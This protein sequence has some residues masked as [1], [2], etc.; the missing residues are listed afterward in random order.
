MH[1]AAGATAALVASGAVCGAVAVAVE[2]ND[3]QGS[4][5]IKMPGRAVA[6]HFHN[7]A[8]AGAPGRP[9]VS[10]STQAIGGGRA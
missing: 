9:S 7:L 4:I 10:W 1:R 3:I 5:R 2:W 8:T 6:A